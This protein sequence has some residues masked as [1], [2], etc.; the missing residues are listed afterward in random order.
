MMDAVAG[1]LMVLAL[2]TFGLSNTL[3]RAHSVA[4]RVIFPGSG[5]VV[6]G[7]CHTIL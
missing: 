6:A 2:P 4:F 7:Q 3:R 1:W 5:I